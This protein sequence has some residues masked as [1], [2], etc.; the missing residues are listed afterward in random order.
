MLII[1]QIKQP[2]TKKGQETLERIVKAGEKLFHELTY[3][4]ASINDIVEL[5]GVGIGTFYLYFD[6]KQSL[7][8]YLVLSYH[9]EIRKEIAE[10]CI[11]CTTREEA[12]KLGFKAYF[13][14]IIKNPYCYTIIWQSLVVDRELFVY[15]YTTFAE[16]YRIGMQRAIDKDEVYDDIDAI[17]IVYALMGITNFF[18]LKISVFQEDTPTEE[19]LDQLVDD[20]MKLL[21]RGMFKKNSGE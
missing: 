21:K 18:G 2:K 10:S 9:H 11:N 14:Y 7:L 6:S 5:A 3:P 15:Y 13:N 8:R 12:E 17:N 19:E 20:A 4:V 1:N 16:K